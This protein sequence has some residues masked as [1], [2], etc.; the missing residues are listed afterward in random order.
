[1]FKYNVHL[2]IKFMAFMASKRI[3]HFVRERRTVAT[4]VDI[5]I[6]ENC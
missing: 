1:M 6:I 5:W 2:H 4:G 3:W